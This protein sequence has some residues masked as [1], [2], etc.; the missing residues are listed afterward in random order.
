MKQ[1]FT[2]FLNLIDDNKL[3]YL[4]KSLHKIDKKELSF[5]YK[6]NQNEVGIIVNNDIYISYN[7]KTTYLECMFRSQPDYTQTFFFLNNIKLTDHYAKYF[8]NKTHNVKNCLIIGLC[9][10][11]M[12]N[13]IFNNKINRIDCVEIN[14]LLCDLYKKFFRISNKIHVYE[15]SGVTFIRKTKKKYDTIFIDIPCQFITS[16]F[17]KNIKNLSTGKVFINLIGE[18]Y[19]KMNIKKIFENFTILNYKVIDE[20]FLYILE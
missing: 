15:E 11:T 3:I 4:D 7:K 14:S 13:A 17:M 12:P 8:I 20:N 9:L 1:Y 18:E 2:K 5:P 6:L 19:H 16:T 10:G